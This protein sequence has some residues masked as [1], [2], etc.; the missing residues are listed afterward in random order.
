MEG[1]DWLLKLFFNA[2]KKIFF[3]HEKH[4][5]EQETSQR[6]LRFALWG[7]L[8]SEEVVNVMTVQGSSYLDKW[9]CLHQT[10]RT[11]DMAP[12]R[13]MAF[14]FPHV[15]SH[16]PKR[17]SKSCQKQCRGGF[18][19]WLNENQWRLCLKISHFLS[20]KLASAH[21]LKEC[22][23]INNVFLH[24]TSKMR[25][26]FIQVYWKKTE[27]ILFRNFKRL[28]GM[29]VVQNVISS[30]QKQVTLRQCESIWKMLLDSRTNNHNL[31]NVG[32]EK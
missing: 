23:A 32:H 2:Q 10:K 7:L 17:T 29:H 25:F 14:I 16:L 21:F 1:I 3:C 24:L 13:L 9:S 4:L 6:L 15:P 27:K 28:V 22:V 8:I 5:P 26:R 19:S 18:L 12:S 11:E 20:T 31:K 30:V